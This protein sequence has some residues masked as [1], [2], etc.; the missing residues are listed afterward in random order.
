[1][2]VSNPGDHHHKHNHSNL[3]THGSG[4]HDGSHAFA[5]PTHYILARTLL[6]GTILV[7]ALAYLLLPF[8]YKVNYDNAWEEQG[9]PPDAIIP[10]KNGKKS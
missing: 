8:L 9:P 7:V 10:G 2:N 1:M 6:G 5:T 4:P 3:S